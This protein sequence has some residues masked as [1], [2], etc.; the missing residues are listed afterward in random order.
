MTSHRCAVHLLSMVCESH[1]AAP[2]SWL[3]PFTC[4]MDIFGDNLAPCLGFSES[5]P[6][7]LI[8]FLVSDTV[9]ASHYSAMH[10]LFHG[11]FH[12]RTS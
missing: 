9:M 12:I 3:G 10:I 2:D 5:H 7:D 6:G 11:R 1:A 4:V 8:S